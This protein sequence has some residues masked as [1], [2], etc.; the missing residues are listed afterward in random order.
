MYF[1][2][3]NILNF[4][5]MRLKLLFGLFIA[6]AL[7]SCKTENNTVDARFEFDR[8]CGKWMDA[9][10][11]NAFNEEWRRERQRD[12]R[13]RGSRSAANGRRSCTKENQPWIKKESPGVRK[14]NP[15]SKERGAPE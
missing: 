5:L 9:N 6:S 2:T 11:D 14:R 15:W 13:G 8:L 4:V 3:T 1:R 7:F 12:Q 10:K